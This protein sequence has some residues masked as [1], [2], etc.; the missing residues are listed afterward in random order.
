VN[1]GMLMFYYWSRLDDV[2]AS[3]FA[4]PMCL[5]L[6]LAAAVFVNAIEQRGWRATRF[7]ALGL[8]I[9]VLGWDLPAIARHLYTSQNLVMQEVEW[10]HDRLQDLPH[11]LLFVTNKSTI[12]FVL[13]HVPSIINGVG[14]LRAEQIKF[15]L[16]QGTFKEIV[17]AQALRPTTPN[18]DMGI[19]PEDLLPPNFRLEPFAEKRFGA[20][21]DRLSRLVAI[22][23][24]TPLT[25]AEAPPERTIAPG[26]ESTVSRAN[27]TPAG[28][29]AA[30]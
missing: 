25:K 12:P 27:P 20:R 11:P 16:E 17:V 24:A 5:L 19:D 18:G 15:H 21:W 10:E 6:G 14:R 7:A 23:P 9:W 29:E 30:L 13:W 8:G 28:P 4:L 2:V 3:R 22:D 26:S 1:L